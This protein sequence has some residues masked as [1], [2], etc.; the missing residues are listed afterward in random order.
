LDHARGHSANDHVEL[1]NGFFDPTCKAVIIAERWARNQAD[2]DHTYFHEVG[3]ATD[4]ALGN[5]SMS[6]DFQNAY[7]QDISKI[8]DKDKVRLDY[9]CNP[10][11]LVE[12]NSCRGLRHSQRAR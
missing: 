12:K 4:S 2:T 9:F 10:V 8:N 3:H 5:I 6:S 11:L 1:V 7:E